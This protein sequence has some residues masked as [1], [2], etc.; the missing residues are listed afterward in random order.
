MKDGAD[1]VKAFTLHDF[2]SSAGQKTF[3][4]FREVVVEI[5]RHHEVE[6]GISQEFQPLIVHPV[7]IFVFH[8]LRSV[9]ESQFIVFNVVRI[10][11]CEVVYKHIKPLILRG[12]ELYE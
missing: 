1:T 6:H 10:E 3:V 9:H 12:K 8:R 7:A 4:F 5:S 2:C 11:T